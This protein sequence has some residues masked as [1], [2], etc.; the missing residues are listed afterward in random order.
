MEESQKDPEGINTVNTRDCP[1]TLETVEE[2]IRRFH[3][4]H[5]QPLRYGLREY[6]ISTVAAHDPTY[7]ANG[8]K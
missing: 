1:K 2:Y 4:V 7:R 8:S 6:L 3:R 5:G